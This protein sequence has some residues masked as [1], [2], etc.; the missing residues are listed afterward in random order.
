MRFDGLDY[1]IVALA[2]Q[3][4]EK[5]GFLEPTS[6]VTA[7][8]AG[9]IHVVQHPGGNPKA[10]VLNHNRLANFDDRYVTYFSDTQGGSSGSPLFNDDFKLIGIHHIGNN[11]VTIAGQSMFTNL[12]SRIE[13]VVQDI[14]R[15]L[16][17]SGLT[18]DALEF[19]F[20]NGPL[21]EMLKN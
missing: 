8:F 12:G 20:G 17:T 16:A 10:Y 13:V 9:Q 21:L 6:G 18:E 19:W 5:F 15:Q 2:E 11:R 14:A 1:T 3:A 4:P 7:Q